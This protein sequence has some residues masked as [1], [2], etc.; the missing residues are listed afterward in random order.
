VDKE[1]NAVDSEFHMSKQN[2]ALR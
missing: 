2:D 1:M